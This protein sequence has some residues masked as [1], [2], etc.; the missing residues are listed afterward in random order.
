M[1]KR[2]QW[3]KFT[4]DREEQFV[5]REDDWKLFEEGRQKVLDLISGKTSTGENKPAEPVKPV[6][7]P[8]ET[9]PLTNGV[10]G[11]KAPQPCPIHT[12]R[13]LFYNPNGRFGPFWSHKTDQVGGN[14]KPVYCNG[15][16]KGKPT[17][18]DEYERIQA[19]PSY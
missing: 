18:I 6:E 11:D 8:V 4:G 1:E 9:K 2:F 16:E 10:A 7:A 15:V 3:S 13:V 19:G 12:N 5:I 17:S 14:G